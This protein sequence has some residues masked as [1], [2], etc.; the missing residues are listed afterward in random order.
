MDAIYYRQHAEL[1]RRLAKGIATRPDIADH[2]RL[3][4]RDYDQIAEDLEVGAIDI[5]HPELMPQVRN[6]GASARPVDR[7]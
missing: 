2:L 7:R 1:G 3:M 6:E 4:A 5:R